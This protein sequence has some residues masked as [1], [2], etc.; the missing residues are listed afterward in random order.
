[1]A[2]N[3]SQI[4][5]VDLE[6]TCWG[7]Q[8]KPDGPNEVIE[9]G[10]ALLGKNGGWEVGDNKSILVRPTTTRVS[11][12]CERLT[13]LTQAEVEKGV[14]FKEA[15]GQLARFSEITFASYGDYDRNQLRKQCDRERVPFPLGQTHLNVKNLA[16]ITRRWDKEVG[17]H[18][19]LKAFGLEPWGTHH[20]GV[21]DA[22]N[23][24]RIL[25]FIL[26]GP[27]TESPRQ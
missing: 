19:A 10:Y 3:L 26:N 11:A 4:I 18:E 21:D 7:P 15:V 23:I 16:A 8:E 27:R 1:V 20:R 12:F 24:A 25:A 14:S 5:V 13:T 2:K 6:A 22:A 9:V 17:M